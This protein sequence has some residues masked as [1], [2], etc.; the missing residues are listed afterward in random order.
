MLV[1]KPDGYDP[2]QGLLPNKTNQKHFNSP[3]E[4]RRTVM[5]SFVLIG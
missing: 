5:S 4:I 1:I 3:R 2:V